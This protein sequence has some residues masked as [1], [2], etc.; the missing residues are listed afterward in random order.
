MNL[1]FLSTARGAWPE[2]SERS[3]L[4]LHFKAGTTSSTAS[5]DSP[6][7]APSSVRI[8]LSSSR[9][10]PGSLPTT[11]IKMVRGTVKNIHRSRSR[12]RGAQ[13]RPIGSPRAARGFPEGSPG[14]SVHNP[15][16]RMESSD[17]LKR[18]Q[19]ILSLIDMLSEMSGD[20]AVEAGSVSFSI[21]VVLRVDRSPQMSPHRQC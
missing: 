5:L 12:S 9:V 15:Y 1:A 6:F 21:V 13:A 2:P 16:A 10:A 20:N 18:K 4:C 11:V 8:S 14:M 19:T 17:P 3:K 7:I